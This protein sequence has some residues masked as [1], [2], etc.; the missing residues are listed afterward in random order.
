M[1]SFLKC[2][3]FFWSP[4]TPHTDIDIPLPLPLTALQPADCWPR[5]SDYGVLGWRAERGS[6]KLDYSQ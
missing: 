6:D 4:Y 2:L 3:S 5:Y 1:S